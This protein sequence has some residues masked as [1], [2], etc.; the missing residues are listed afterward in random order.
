MGQLSFLQVCMPQHASS[1]LAEG[2]KG[3]VGCTL[4]SLVL[5][6]PWL[7]HPQGWL[8]LWGPL[9]GSFPEGWGERAPEDWACWARQGGSSAPVSPDTTGSTAACSKPPCCHGSC[10]HE[11]ED[12]ARATR[13]LPSRAGSGHRPLH[14]ARPQTTGPEPAELCA[15]QV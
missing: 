1:G 6:P 15:S 10:H 11:E 13:V 14:T 12:T 5:R 4:R 9:W 3:Q 7:S 8:L 2:R